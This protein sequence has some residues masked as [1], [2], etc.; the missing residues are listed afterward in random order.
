MDIQFQSSWRYDLRHHPG[1]RRGL[2]IFAYR[3]RWIL[4]GTFDLTISDAWIS[5]GD[6]RGHDG[7]RAKT[8]LAN[9]VHSRLPIALCSAC[10]ASRREPMVIPQ[11]SAHPAL[12]FL[13]LAPELFDFK[14]ELNRAASV[15]VL[16]GFFLFHISLDEQVLYVGYSVPFLLSGIYSFF[17]CQS[18]SDN[19]ARAS[20]HCRNAIGPQLCQFPS[21]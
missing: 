11:R 6:S 13:F 7:Q 8:G 12:D 16:Q 5:K 21:R 20:R 4:Q 1:G 15:S 18:P 9:T 10:R 17:H 3:R 19:P 14:L 2:S